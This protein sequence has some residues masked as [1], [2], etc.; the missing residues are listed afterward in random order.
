MR[1]RVLLM[2]CCLAL[3]ISAASAATEYLKLATM[4]AQGWSTTVRVDSSG[5]GGV[6]EKADGYGGEPTGTFMFTN[7]S[8]SRVANP[9]ASISTAQFDGVQLS[10]LTA[11]TMRVSGFEGA[12]TEWQPPH[13]A[14][15]LTDSAGNHRCAEWIPW[16]DGIPRDPGNS[17]DGHWNTYD[18]LVDGQW[19]VP[20][21]NS[22]APHYG[23]FSTVASMLAT[24]PTLV[25][26]DPSA[27]SGTEGFYGT[28]F[29]VGYAC[30]VTDVNPY[31]ND[32]RGLVDWFDVGIDG[33]TTRYYLNEVPEPGSLLALAT[34][35][36]G[37]LG[38]RRRF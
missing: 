3:C 13:F 12:G 19:Y 34:G 30:W 23:R 35:L 9:W 15:A 8:I 16:A 7:G 5:R 33:A 20:W 21:Y 4:G 38:L 32:A 6:Y 37:F 11:L 17:V 31:S 1:L 29:N 18:A 10:R 25:F 28:S 24:F 22:V 26:V 36:I 27:I 14:F 2:V